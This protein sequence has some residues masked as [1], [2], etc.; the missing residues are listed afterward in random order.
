[1][2]YRAKK[3]KLK[4]KIERMYRVAVVDENEDELIEDWT[5]GTREEAKELGLKL[6]REVMEARGEWKCL[7]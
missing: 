3:P 7:S 4:V 6:K 2:T 1:M 5:F